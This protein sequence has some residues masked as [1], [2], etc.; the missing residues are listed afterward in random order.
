MF[1]IK[2][3]GN[4]DLEASQYL[5]P[6]KPRPRGFEALLVPGAGCCLELIGLIAANSPQLEI[7]VKTDPLYGAQITFMA[8]PPLRRQTLGRRRW[9]AKRCQAQLRKKSSNSLS[10]VF[11][12]SMK[13]YVWCPILF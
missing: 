2:L 1:S 8:P 13:N 3:G 6:Q 11:C 12:P 5:N 10:L 7:R 4:L 9:A